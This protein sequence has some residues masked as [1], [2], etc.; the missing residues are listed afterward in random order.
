MPE[1]I[2]MVGQ[3]AW[4]CAV[5]HL[6]E[7]NDHTVTYVPRDQRKWSETG[8]PD[9]VFLA[10]PTQALRE[11]LST[12]PHPQVPVVSLMKGL[13][14]E[15]MS[16]VSQIVR[17]VWPGAAMACISGP[18]FAVEV[19]RNS[20]SAAVVASDVDGL[21]TAI[22]QIVHQKWFR[23]YRSDDLTGVELGGA[24]KNVYALAGG[25]CEGLGVGANGMAALMTRAL[26]EMLRIATCLEARPET[27]YGLSGMGDLVLTAYSRISRNHQAGVA[28]GQGKSIEDIHQSVPGTI[29]GVATVRA[30]NHLAC[31]RGL[32]A[33]IVQEIYQ[34]LYEG[35]TPA[36]GMEALLTRSVS[37]E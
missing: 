36:D 28:L 11:R 8:A 33:P 10:I 20:P 16:R 18:T 9:Y 4:A 14:V 35:K 29:E 31:E 21:A 27:L 13:E 15:T 23:L 5:G 37:E 26:A 3:G 25:M 32:K 7:Q 17:D 22:Q 30:V 24:L 34:V 1:N 2:Q 19:E 12:L 6:L